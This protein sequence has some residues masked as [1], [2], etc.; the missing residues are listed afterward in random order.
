MILKII[1][2]WISTQSPWLPDS[3]L[4]DARCHRW[5]WS[6][7]LRSS[8]GFSWFFV[9]PNWCENL[10]KGEKDARP[11]NHVW[12]ENA[13]TII[14]EIH[15]A[16]PVKHQPG[17]EEADRSEISWTSLI[18][19][20]QL[21]SQTLPNHDTKSCLFHWP[22]LCPE[23]TTQI[24]CQFHLS[25]ASSEPSLRAIEGRW[26]GTTDRRGEPG[27]PSWPSWRKK[28]AKWNALMAEIQIPSWFI[29]IDVPSDSANQV[30]LYLD[31][32]QLQQQQVLITLHFHIK[33]HHCST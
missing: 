11:S 15:E 28:T 17:C 27:L 4:T 9:Q 22:P 13:Y 32:T 24:F 10:P 6:W 19:Y 23:L 20:I 33:I 21:V 3:W 7:N 30:V 31:S 1:S 12:S 26:L 8:V 14:P 2:L 18:Q 16:I 29:S 5:S 25:L